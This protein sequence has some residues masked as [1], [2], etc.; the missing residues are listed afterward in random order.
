M[1]VVQHFKVKGG[2]AKGPSE[3]VWLLGAIVRV[4]GVVIG[5]PQV[6][7]PQYGQIPYYVALSA[8]LRLPL[9]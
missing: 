9:S 1:L 3:G 4:V 8:G 5:G 2:S 7:A 6:P